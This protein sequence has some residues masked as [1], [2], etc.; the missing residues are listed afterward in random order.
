LRHP[1]IVNKTKN[2]RYF[3]CKPLH[4]IFVDRK[5]VNPEIQGELKMPVEGKEIGD[6]EMIEEL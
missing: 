5:F 6:T 4:G 2:Y 3:Q 1:V